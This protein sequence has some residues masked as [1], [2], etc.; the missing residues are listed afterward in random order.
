MAFIPLKL[1]PGVYK[2]GT[3]YQAQGRWND[4]NLVRWFEGTM[5]PV[6]GWRNRRGGSPR[7][8]LQVS[9]A[10]R[11]AFSWRE[12]D[13]TKWYVIGTHTGLYVAESGS[14][15]LTNIAINDLAAGRINSNNAVGFGNSTYGYDEYGI[16]RQ[17]TGTVLDA[18]TW[19]FDNFGQI[20][21][22][23]NSDDGRILIWDNNV[24]NDVTV[25]TPSAGTVPINNGGIVVTQERYVFALGAGGNPR[26]IQWCDQED[27]T[28]WEVTATTTAG[29]FELTTNGRIQLGKR[30]RDQVLILTTADAHVAN[31]V[32]PP[33]VYGFEKIASGCGAISRNSCLTADNIAIWMGDDGFWLYDGYVKPL[34][35]EVSDYVFS[36]LNISQK[37]KVYGVLNSQFFEMWFYYPS[38]SSMENDRYVVYNYRE[39]HWTIGNLS[40]TCGMDVD[41]FNY[42]ILVDASGYVYDHEVGNQY[43]GQVPYA[44]SGP[45]ELGNGDQ[46]MM[47]RHLIPDEKT[48]GDVQVSFSTQFYPDAVA[49]THGPYSMAN[50]TSVR[51]T[52]RQVAMKVQGV[53]EVD[54]RFGTPRLDVAAGSR[55]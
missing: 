15:P 28:N 32:G 18:T 24:A 30:V 7:A 42:P 29:D 22:A 46:T 2:N 39:N 12:N 1:A 37:A 47:A 27:Y 14:G 5:R 51:F 44:E 50:P 33:F 52:G 38:G 9:G 49:Y 54:W 41:V 19:S 36:D 8:D 17:D 40:R 34:P 23:V 35:C 48:Q 26:K 20:L 10:A 6:G 4:A 16:A 11:G 45:I 53:R 21:L 3:N 55:R 13:G 25:I 43:S 31:Y